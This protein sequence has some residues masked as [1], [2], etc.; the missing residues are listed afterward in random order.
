MHISHRRALLGAPALLT[1]PGILRRRV[2]TTDGVMTFDR[3]TIDSA[4]VFLIGELE[5]L[6]QKLHMPLT[7]VTWPRD[8]DLREDVTIADEASSFTN[9]SFAAPGGLAP[10][11]KAFIS[12]NANVIPG[13]ALDIGKTM[14]PLHLWGMELKWTIPELKSAEALGRPIDSQKLE[15]LRMKHNMDV[16]EMVYI[17][18]DYIS[19]TGLCNHASVTP[20]NVANGASG[21]PLWANKTPDEILAD[22]NTSLNAVWS[23]SALAVAPEEVRLPPAKFAY[24]AGQKVS[25]AGSATILEYV[26]EKCISSVVNNKPLNIQPLKWCTGRG[27]GATDRMVVYTRNTEYVRYPMVPLQRTPLEYR[28]L[29]QITT[30]YGRLGEVEMPYPETVGYFDGF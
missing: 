28:S 17:G 20:A 8:I 21:S 30:Y 12:K 7:S 3:N 1:A 24:I 5:K 29:F 16:D 18:D 11:G 4:G 2:F 15:G 9:S 6:D 27:A 19:A 14:K 13:I 23:A 25:E 10:A 26:R 22:F